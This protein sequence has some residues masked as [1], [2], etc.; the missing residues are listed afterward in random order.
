MLFN[1]MYKHLA[2]YLINPIYIIYYFIVG[3]DFLYN[4]ERNYFY[5]FLNL[6]IL[7][8]F[9]IFGLIYNEFLV[10]SCCGMGYNT[11]NS[12]SLRASIYEEMSA[13]YDD[14]IDDE[15]KF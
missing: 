5:F 9:D 6:I 4:G 15:N 8:I 14:N 13:L 10:V 12:I 1:P 11:Y 3:E 2:D 7:I